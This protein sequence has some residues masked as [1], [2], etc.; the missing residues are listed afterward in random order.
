MIPMLKGKQK[1]AK[2]A[3]IR[4]VKKIREP[5]LARFTIKA[6]RAKG[7]IE[8][9]RILSKLSFMKLCWMGK[10]RTLACEIV[11]SE[12]LQQNPYLFARLEFRQDRLDVEYSITPEANAKKRELDICR[13]V[14]DV[15]ALTDAYEAGIGALYGR[16]A[17]ALS[18]A[19][20]FATMDY[21]TLKN[22]HDELASECGRL[23]KRGAELTS[24]NEKQSKLLME[25][26]KR[27][28]ALRKGFP[29]WRG[30]GTIHSWRSSAPGSPPTPAS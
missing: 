7:T 30:W 22:R 10:K 11:E 4:K 13:L 24:V 2:S 8:L 6:K 23:R 12:D 18:G 17:C 19:V 20:E 27:A 28:E 1:D 29:A 14:L 9:R 21:E 25:S 5:E 26:E 3:E 15:L 16:I